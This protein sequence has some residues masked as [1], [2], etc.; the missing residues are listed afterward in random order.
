MRVVWVGKAAS[1]LA[2]LH[3][4]LAEVN[5]RA[6]KV[7]VRKLIAAPLGLSDAPRMGGRLVEFAPREIRRIFAGDYEL[8]Y[9]IVEETIYV[10][11]VWHVRE[12][13]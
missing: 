1:D 6:A 3:A 11:R 13:R 2:R 9:E 12:D 10:L 5:P 7:V 4:F 8:R